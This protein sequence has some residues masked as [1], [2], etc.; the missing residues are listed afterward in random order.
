MNQTTHEP[1]HLSSEELSILSELLE[2]ARTNLLVEIRHTDHRSYRDDL[3]R[4]LI[5]MEHLI[6]RCRR[7]GYAGSA[8]SEPHPYEHASG[9]G[10]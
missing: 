3:R 2:S 5:I 9:A 10:R 6:Q 1:L 8:E 4:R 7:H